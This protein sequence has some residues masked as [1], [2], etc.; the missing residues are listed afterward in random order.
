MVNLWHAWQWAL[1]LDAEPKSFT[2]LQVCLRSV[3]TYGVGLLIMRLARNRL[4]TQASVFDVVLGFVLGS[5]LS[6][7][8]NGTSPLSLSLAAAAALVASHHSLA[9]LSYRSP[10]LRALIGG[11][12]N[13]VV[14]QGEPLG[15]NLRRH[16]LSQADLAEELRLQHF[17]GLSGIAE[18]RVERSGAI[19]VVREPRVLEV[20]VEAGVQTVRIEVV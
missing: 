17:A 14:R 11:R 19:S 6:R 1:G 4:L 12:S 20:K 9:W 8:I 18:A 13:V 2:V 7:G 16:L 3:L 5:V 15:E 10:R